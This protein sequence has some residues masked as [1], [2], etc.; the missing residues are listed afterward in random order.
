M[1]VIPL[2]EANANLRRYG[3]LCIA[4]RVIVTVNGVP[5]FQ[6]ASLAQNDDMINRLLT[7]NPKFRQLLEQRSRERTVSTVEARK[8]L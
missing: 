1:K 4:E 7:E 8:R 6:L 2:S 5:A 3:K